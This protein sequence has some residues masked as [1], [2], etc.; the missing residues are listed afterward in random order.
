MSQ[1]PPTQPPSPATALA[2]HLRTLAKLAD[3]LANDY[4]EPAAPATIPPPAALTSTAAGGEAAATSLAA[5]A[6]D[7]PTDKHRGAKCR[8]VLA[9]VEKHPKASVDEIMA[10]VGCVRSY[11]GDCLKKKYK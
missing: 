11:V 7:P 2:S 5:P 3:A 4:S 10:A 6:S 8:A 1:P 9:F